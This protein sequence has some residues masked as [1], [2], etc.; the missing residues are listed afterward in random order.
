MRFIWSFLT[1]LLIISFYPSMLLGMDMDHSQPQHDMSQMQHDMHG[2]GMWMFGY[3]FMR[4][5]MDELLQGR[6]TISTRT[7]SGAIPGMPPTKAPGK[8]YRM[9]PTEM[10]MDMH[11]F[12][13]M[14]GLTDRFMVMGMAQYLDNDMDMIMHMPATDMFGSMQTSGMG[15]TV[16]SGEYKINRKWSAGLGLSLPTGSIS[17]KITMVMTAPGGGSTPPNTMQAP[18]PMQLGSGTYDLI[19]KVEYSDGNDKWSWGGDINLTLRLGE[20]N[21]NYT[22]GDRIEVGAWGAYKLNR[23]LIISARIDYLDWGSIDGQDP[24]IN[25]M[26]A[27]TSDPNAQ[28]GSRAD[29]SFGV[30]APFGQGHSF[31]L[32]VG[33]PFYQDLNG[34]QL[35]TDLI[36]KAGLSFML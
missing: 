13:A 4:M 18:Y 24:E 35:E 9:S 11:M 27:P 28:G 34:P 2:A 6:D 17:E 30:R 1:F 29:I 15:D 14:Y 5:D 7:I 16:V 36:L 31:E 25:P 12:M 21:N 10:T 33:V 20:N 19:P 8:Q 26:M 22:L 32:E 3:Q 23:N